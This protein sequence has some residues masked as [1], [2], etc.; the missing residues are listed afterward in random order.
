MPEGFELRGLRLAHL[1][2]VL[3]VA[4]AEAPATR[5]RR[6]A[7]LRSLLTFAHR[8][9]YL[10]IN[11]G[12]VLREPKVPRKI[13]GRVLSVGDVAA[14][15][16]AAGLAP[17]MGARDRAFVRLLYACAARVEEACGLSWRDVTRRE[18]GSASL[19]IVGKGG[20][21]RSV[22]IPASTIGPLDELAGS[23]GDADPT[24]ALVMSARGTRL[25]KRDAQR[26]V[27]RAAR[28]AGLVLS[29]SPHWFRHAHATHA[30]EAGAPVHVVASD[31]GHASVATTT[32]YLHARPTTGSAAFLPI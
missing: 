22:W 23:A 11:V 3:E 30:L 29:V 15:I 9:G 5:A 25:G 32:I 27:K 31:L 8:V 19:E 20:R 13:A 12:A 10:A 6:V 17:R 16:H 24:R 7:A 4:P 14:L 28:R 21:V 1:R 2:S 18:D 26:I